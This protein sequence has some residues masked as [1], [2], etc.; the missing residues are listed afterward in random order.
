MICLASAAKGDKGQKNNAAICFRESGFK[1]LESRIWSQASGVKDLESS[2][3][4]QASGVKHLIPSRF[5]HGTQQ[6]IAQ[7]WHV[8]VIRLAFA[9]GG[10]STS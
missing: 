4:S 1:D 2:I 6:R 7:A 8:S 10:T 5:Q 3:W 9:C